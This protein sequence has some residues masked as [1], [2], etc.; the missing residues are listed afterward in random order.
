MGRALFSHSFNAPSAPPVAVAVRA[1]P[2]LEPPRWDPHTGI[3]PDSDEFFEGAV[4]EAFVNPEDMVI[5]PDMPAL[6]DPDSPMT[7]PVAPS[8]PG[9]PPPLLPAGLEADPAPRRLLDQYG[10]RR[11]STGP[12]RRY[13]D[14]H[15]QLFPAPENYPPPALPASI[16]RT[17]AQYEYID[18]TL[19]GTLRTTP[20]QDIIAASRRAAPEPNLPRPTPPPSSE[21]EARTA[22]RDALRAAAI[23]RQGAMAAAAAAGVSA[24]TIAATAARNSSTINAAL[25]VATAQ[26]LSLQAHIRMLEDAVSG[27]GSLASNLSDV[28]RV[29]RQTASAIHDRAALPMA[30]DDDYNSGLADHFTYDQRANTN[31]AAGNAIRAPDFVPA[32]L[33]TS[34]PRLYIPTSAPA[35]AASPA[36]ATSDVRSLRLP[37]PRLSV[38]LGASAPRTRLRSASTSAISN[39]S[40]TNALTHRDPWF[41][42]T[43]RARPVMVHRATNAVPGSARTSS[44][45]SSRG[46]SADSSRATSLDSTPESSAPVTPEPRFVTPYIFSES[47]SA[48]GFPLT[49]SS[50][51]APFAP[52]VTVV[53]SYQSQSTTTPRPRTITT[54]VFGGDTP[55]PLVSPRDENDPRTTRRTSQDRQRAMNTDILTDAHEAYWGRDW[56]ARSAGRA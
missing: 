46:S 31:T 45:S 44:S 53:T 39:T 5:Q 38:D 20:P 48:S 40:T 24:S 25:S 29:T 33:R 12:Q 41:T 30:S 1:E 22:V 37:H 56:P 10:L 6:E 23:A 43:P 19:G 35:P 3:D 51:S 28:A 26:T 42:A 13:L 2:A 49:T 9:S 16:S 14:P 18:P 11:V 21:T 54:T 8:P 7:L 32:T 15:I 4:Y 17:P 47:N 27:L 52:A 50:S 34:I 36:P 55:P